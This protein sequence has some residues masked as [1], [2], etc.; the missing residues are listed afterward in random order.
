MTKPAAPERRAK[1]L[2]EVVDYILS[3]GLAGLSLRPLAAGVNTSPRMLLYFFGSKEQLISEALAQIRLRQ[4]ADFARAMSGRGGRQE[5][6][7]TSVGRLD[8]SQD[9]EIWEVLFWSLRVR[10]SESQTVRGIPGAV[11]R[12]LVAAVR[13][14]AGRRRLFSRTC[15]RSGNSVA[16]RDARAATGPACYW[17]ARPYRRGIPGDVETV[18]V[19]LP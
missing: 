16:G 4:Q 5:R 8:F 18:G 12:R 15:A 13:A 14:G 17:R 1:L 9:G 11:Y 19:G 10:A 7:A 2:N 6:S 3:N